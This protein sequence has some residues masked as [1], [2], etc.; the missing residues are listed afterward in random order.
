MKKAGFKKVIESEESG[1]IL[2]SG[3]GSK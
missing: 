2:L 3:L 1:F